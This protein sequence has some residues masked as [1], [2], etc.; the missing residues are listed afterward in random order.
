MYWWAAAIAVRLFGWNEIA[1]RA[2]SILATAMTAAI[3]Y[4]WL[5]SSSAVESPFGPCRV[6][7][8]PVYR[9]CGAPASDGRDPDDVPD[10]RDGLPRARD[11]RE[12]RREKILLAIAAVSMGGAILTK[13]PL[14]VVLPGLA[15]AIFLRF[16]QRVIRAISIRCDRDLRGASRSARSGT[17]RRCARWQ[18]VLRISNC[19]RT[20]APISRRQRGHR[21]RMPESCLLFHSAVGFRISAVEPLLSRAALMLWTNRA[22]DA[23][24]SYFRAMLVRRD[25]RIFYASRPASASS[26]YCRCFPRS[27]R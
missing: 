15:L 20:V 14:G 19:P 6:A 3:L 12:S 1:L 25:S 13:G 18:R 24:A 8:N 26:I 22:K 4:A 10:R 21:R 27:P 11:S 2:P 23:T 5:G 17:S 9:R 7:V 16:G